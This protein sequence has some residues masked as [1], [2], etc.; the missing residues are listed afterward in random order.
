[1]YPIALS[2]VVK[3]SFHTDYHELFPQIEAFKNEAKVESSKYEFMIYQIL[4]QCCYESKKGL[5]NTQ[6]L[7]N[8]LM[9]PDTDALLSS[10]DAKMSLSVMTIRI[11][12]KLLNIGLQK[13]VNDILGDG[14]DGAD[15]QIVGRIWGSIALNCIK[16]P[17]GSALYGLPSF[18]NHSCKPNVGIHF[19]KYNLVSL[20]SLRD[21]GKTEE[22]SI[23][24]CESDTEANQWSAEQQQQHLL[25]N[26]GINCKNCTTCK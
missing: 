4:L 14:K 8:L 7:L 22:L 6:L 21:I 13:Q 25:Y 19:D 11:K 2:E 18:L 10:A 12:N 3:E 20:V 9:S 15:I 5:N 17:R 24:Y 1:M 23:H 26:Y 16:T